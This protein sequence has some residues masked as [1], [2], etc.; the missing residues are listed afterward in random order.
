[1]QTIQMIITAN[2]YLGLRPVNPIRDWQDWKQNHVER[3]AV[4]RGVSLGPHPPGVEP[5]VAQVND[6]RWIVYCPSPDCAGAEFAWEEGE[7]MCMSCFNAHVGHCFLP[8]RFPD[9]RLEIEGILNMR[10][11]MYNRHWYIH[12]SLSDLRHQNVEH[13]YSFPV[14]A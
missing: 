11:S 4:R 13:G 3:A 6:G 10:P 8:S 2:H 5:I 7:F 14:G 12:E 1:M 9:E